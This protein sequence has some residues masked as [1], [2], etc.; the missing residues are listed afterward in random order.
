MS[1]NIVFLDAATIGSDIDLS[2]FENYGKLT[3]FESTAQ[4]EFIQ[5]VG[6]SDVIIINKLKVGRDN[7]PYCKRVKLVCVTATGYDNIDLAYCREKGIAVCNVVG[8]STESVAQ[9]TLSMVLSLATNLSAYHA[10]VADGRYTE[11]GVANAVSPVFHEL[12][13]RTWGVFGYGNIGKKVA[14]VADAIG[15]RVLV[16]KRTKTE[17]DYPVVDLDTLCRESDVLTVHSPLTEQ[18]R[19]IFDRAH[20]ALMKKDAI[21]VNGARGAVLDEAAVADAILSGALG[22]FGCDVYTREPF[23]RSH[24]YTA[25][26]AHPRVILTPHMAWGSYEARSLCLDEICHNIT[27]FFNGEIRNR[28]DLA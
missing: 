25:L 14:R 17:E 13:G 26:L 4:D 21:L 2:M 3:V 18:T 28:V 1:L 15:C 5:N 12:A 8:Y 6:D 11:S 24:P 10:Y 16:C 19:G 23:A 9:L 20:L 27:C 22:G 7:L